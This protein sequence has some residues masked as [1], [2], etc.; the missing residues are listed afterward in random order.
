MPTVAHPP[1]YR[2]LRRITL[3]AVV[4]L[5]GVLGLRMWT[6]WR[7][8]QRLDAA[9][10]AIRGRGEPML[11]DDLRVPPLPPGENRAVYL[12]RALANWPRVA[13]TTQ[14]IVETPWK[15]QE[16]T[17]SR[18][19]PAPPLPDP[20]PDNAAYLASLEAE[21][22]VLAEMRGADAVG[23]TD[24]G[25]PLTQPLF[26]MLLP[27][28]GDSRKLARLMMDAAERAAAEGDAALALEL[29]RLT[30][31]IA[32]AQY[33]VRPRTLIGGLVAMSIQS[34]PLGELMETLPVLSLDTPEARAEAERL[35]TVL[36]DDEA[37]ERSQRDVW[38]DERAVLH[39]TVM[40]I[41]DPPPSM[42]NTAMALGSHP[43]YDLAFSPPG[44]WLLRPVHLDAA[45]RSLA[46][47]TRKIEVQQ[48]A[49]GT[50]GHYHWTMQDDERIYRQRAMPLS[51][52]RDAFTLTLMPAYAAATRSE[53]RLSIVRRCAA[54]A[55]AVKLYEA[56]HGHR[57]ATLAELVPAYLDAVPVDPMRADGGPVGYRAGA[58]DAGPA[59]V[60]SVG[61]D[62]EDDG[63]RV[64]VQSDGTYDQ[65]T[66]FDDQNDHWFLLDPE[67]KPTVP[68][69][70][71]A[72]DAIQPFDF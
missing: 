61:M 32:D 52:L 27:Q 29:I 63:G 56:D 46:M 64:V 59:V 16:E 20:I 2:W 60:Y 58:S 35:L 33:E 1:R 23:G 40:F 7:S 21:G 68:S 34:L 38:I 55:L 49:Q 8:Q 42:P 66:R 6:G 4:V 54:V 70:P 14:T 62:G 18:L 72:P 57:P 3:I 69:A 31:R 25:V 24:W 48:Q 17:R 15:R 26:N 71:D 53:M 30:F 39:D 9:V 28:L 43:V 41:I 11:I 65:V 67:P 44:R 5:L 12:K 45:R 50:A 10:A 36:R 13:G 22:G 19:S 51:M 47:M 37:F